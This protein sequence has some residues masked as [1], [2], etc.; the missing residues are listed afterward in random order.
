MSRA[1]P[2]QGVSFDGDA[3]FIDLLG[4]TVSEFDAVDGSRTGA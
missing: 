2:W 1:L 3:R 4:A